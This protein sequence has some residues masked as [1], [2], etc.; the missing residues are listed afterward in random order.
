MSVLIW[1]IGQFL[2]CTT[3][4]TH[5]SSP[6]VLSPKHVEMTGAYAWQMNGVVV[7]K[8]LSS[9]KVLYEKATEE[10][11]QMTEEEFRGL[12]D[13]TLAWSL[14]TPGSSYEIVGR[15]GLTDKLLQ[16]IDIGFK[17][18]FS[19]IKA[20][21]K[22]QLWESQKGNQALAWTGA[23][24]HQRSLV[25][26]QIE[27][28]TNS[29]F[30]RHDFDTSLM[31]GIRK[32]GISEFYAGPRFMYSYIDAQPNLTSDMTLR[33]PEEFQALNPSEYF[34]DERMM[35]YGGTIGTRFG[36]HVAFVTLEVNCLWVDFNPYVIDQ[37]R[38]LSGLLVSPAAAIT[39][40][41]GEYMQLQQKLE[42]DW[43]RKL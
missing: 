26:S 39:I 31:W 38:P 9:A 40:V 4:T 32:K 20:D 14:M 7:D 1:S 11:R 2:G 33:I 27:W 23:Y 3:T 25:N 30:S 43:D 29:S 19:T 37:N 42:K 36:Y 41:P 16:G 6:F 12:L 10:E 8:S 15:V 35:F 5:L 22:W 21:V 28:A 13:T 18:D 34:Q 24:A 17:T